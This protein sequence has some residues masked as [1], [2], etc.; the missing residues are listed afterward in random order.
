MP[1]CCVASLPA[2]LCVMEILSLMS[3]MLSPSALN[4]VPIY[5]NDHTFFSFSPSQSITGLFFLHFHHLIMPRVSICCRTMLYPRRVNARDVSFHVSLS[6]EALAALIVAPDVI[7][8]C[9]ELHTGVQ[10]TLF[11][12]LLDRLLTALVL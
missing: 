12:E 7:G 2:V 4:L 1:I 6:L 5:L 8:V 3:V 10:T 9:I 11:P